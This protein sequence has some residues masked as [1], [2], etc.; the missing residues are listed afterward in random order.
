[1]KER[2]YLEDLSIDERIL[3]RVFKYRERGRAV[4]NAV[5]NLRIPYRVGNF[6][7]D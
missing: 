5:M 3:K 6:L 7:I 2:D 1:M 4:L